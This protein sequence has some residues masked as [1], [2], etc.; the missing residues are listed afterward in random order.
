[1]LNIDFMAMANYLSYW[2][3]PMTC[4]FISLSLVRNM[5]L[6]NGFVETLCRILYDIIFILFLQSRHVCLFKMEIINN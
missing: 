3:Y 4:D 2:E 1:M 5:N 6:V